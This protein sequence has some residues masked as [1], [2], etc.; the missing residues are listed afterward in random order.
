[1]ITFGTL[2]ELRE[3]KEAFQ[4]QLHTAQ[5]EMDHLRTITRGQRDRGPKE[6]SRR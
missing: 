5:S 4:A 1:M 6:L 2:C 3:I